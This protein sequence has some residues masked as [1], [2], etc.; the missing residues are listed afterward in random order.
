MHSWYRRS[1]PLRLMWLWVSWSGT[2]SAWSARRNS[3]G[4]YVRR[5]WV[6]S[7]VVGEARSARS[8]RVQLVPSLLLFVPPWMMHDHIRS[9]FCDP[10]TTGS[11]S[12]L[13]I[14]FIRNRMIQL[15]YL[16][17]CF[18]LAI[19]YFFSSFSSSSLE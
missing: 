11:W 2:S 12:C 16:T 5:K 9:S 17:V 19:Y 7:I 4:G 10:S 14:S 3:T 6:S 18:S 15:L 1:R 8:L 13:E